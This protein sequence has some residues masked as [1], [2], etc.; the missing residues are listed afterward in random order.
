MEQKPVP[1]VV[2]LTQGFTMGGRNLACIFHVRAVGK[3]SPY[4]QAD[5]DDITTFFNTQFNLQFKP[6]MS[7]Q[8]SITQTLARDL[9]NDFGL[10][11]VQGGIGFGTSA[12]APLPNNVAVCISWPTGRRYKGGHPRSYIP[13]VVQSDLQDGTTFTNACVTAY[14]TAAATLRTNINSHNIPSTGVLNLVTVSRVKNKVLLDPPLVYAV[15]APLVDNRIDS[16][17]RRLGRDR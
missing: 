10:T 17:R 4:D 14:T 7:N 2:R 12:T 3:V 6:R 11:S 9:T 13:G 16:Q 1:G 15:S 5:M 8:C